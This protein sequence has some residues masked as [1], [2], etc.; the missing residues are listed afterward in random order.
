MPQK[1]LI[2]DKAQMDEAIDRIADEIIAEFK[3]TSKNSNPIALLGI[4]RQG[5]PFA[6]RLGAAIERKT[7]RRPPEGILDISMYR[8]DYGL[9]KTLPVIYETVIPFN[10]DECNVIIADDVLASGRTIR[11]ALD[12]LTDY[13]RPRI[14]RLATL[15]DRG[16]NEYPIRADY[17]GL[18]HKTAPNRKIVVEFEESN[19]ADG[20][21]EKHW[22]KGGDYK[23]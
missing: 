17:V 23:A 19:G 20:I 3:V 21:F 16:C 1:K 2:F 15:L 7:G 9:R 22:D 18:R 10:V 5:V 11:A 12:A 8:D 4:Q 6:R 14:I 13:G